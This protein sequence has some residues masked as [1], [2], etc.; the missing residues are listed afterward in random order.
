MTLCTERSNAHL[1]VAKLCTLYLSTR[2]NSK[3]ADLQTSG[4]RIT[5]NCFSQIS[6][7]GHWTVCTKCG[8]WRLCDKITW[9]CEVQIFFKDS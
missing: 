3:D 2:S 8:P 4:H 7:G 6:V 9:Y 5:L 1:T